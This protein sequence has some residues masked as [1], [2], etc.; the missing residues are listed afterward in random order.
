MALGKDRRT[1]RRVSDKG[2]PPG[3]NFDRRPYDL[4]DDMAETLADAN[5]AG[6]AAP[7]WGSC[8]GSVWCWT[9]KRRSI[10]S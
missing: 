1:G 3:E 8:A 5:G 6:L 10:W 7:R 9:R 2:L 4:L